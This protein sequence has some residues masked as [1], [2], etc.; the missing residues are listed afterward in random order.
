M[1]LREASQNYK[2]VQGRLSCLGRQLDR[3]RHDRQIGADDRLSILPP[4][5][6]FSGQPGEG[7]AEMSE[8]A[9]KNGRVIR[10]VL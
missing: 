6:K 9:T 5:L 3:S 1:K 8:F 10:S 4:S 2:Q 7:R